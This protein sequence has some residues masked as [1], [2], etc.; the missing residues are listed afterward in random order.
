M[1]LIVILTMQVGGTTPISRGAVKE[2]KDHNILR[3]TNNHPTNRK[4]SQT[5]KRCSQS[6][7]RCRK[8]VFRTLRQH[9]KINKLRSKGLKLR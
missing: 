7:F 9:L 4:R 2:I 1:I 5:L 6:L 8:L 3:A